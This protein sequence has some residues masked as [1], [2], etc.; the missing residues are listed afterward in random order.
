MTTHNKQKHLGNVFGNW[1]AI[2]DL[3]GEIWK[4]V[5]EYEGLYQVSNKGR[6]K[7]NNHLIKPVVQKTG[8]L[9]VSLCKNGINKTYRVH[10]L[11]AKV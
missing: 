7:R 10:K 4:D 2:E 9:N 6:I 3:E 5:P 11:I 8:Y 1:T